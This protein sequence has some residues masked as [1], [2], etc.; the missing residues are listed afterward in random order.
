MSD[1]LWK[2]LANSVI[3]S[4][5]IIRFIFK[6]SPSVQLA[7]RMYLKSVVADTIWRTHGSTL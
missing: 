7:G 2:S 6:V 5:D 3:Q 4:P 1:F